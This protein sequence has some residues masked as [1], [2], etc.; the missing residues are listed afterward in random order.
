MSY[1]RGLCLNITVSCLSALVR[2]YDLLL[3]L[4]CCVFVLCT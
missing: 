1:F 3:V 2:T 4:C